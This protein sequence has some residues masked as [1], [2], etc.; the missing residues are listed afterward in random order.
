MGI[1]VSHEATGAISDLAFWGGNLAGENQRRQQDRDQKAKDDQVRIQM[2]QIAAANERAAV[3]QQLQRER[4]EIDQAAYENAPQHALEMGRVEN[5]LEGE[6]ENF[7]YSVSQKRERSKLSEARDYVTQNNGNTYTQDEQEI[8]LKQ[9]DQREA[10]IIPNER[11]DQPWSKDQDVGRVWVDANSGA[12]MTRDDKGNVKVLVQ[13]Q[14]VNSFDNQL[15]MKKQVSDLA[16]TLM[17]SS[18]EYAEAMSFSDATSQ[19]QQFY[20]DMMS[21]PDVS[22]QA[23]QSPSV[24]QSAQVAS[25][26]PQNLD[27]RGEQVMGLALSDPSGFI[28]WSMK[29]HG[30]ETALELEIILKSKDK[31]AIQEAL[32]RLGVL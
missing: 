2:A 24:S 6:K 16:S 8:L 22:Q 7:D 17:K 32:K 20:T 21:Q 11:V 28:D 1:K 30:R 13:S 12:T 26:P 23:L 19:A 29:T 9:I 14:N 5:Q 15:K 4:M 25:Q 3:A 27:A 31:T 10:G 18:G